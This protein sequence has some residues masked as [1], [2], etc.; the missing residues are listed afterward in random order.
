M[1]TV[2]APYR[3]Y[4][5]GVAGRRQPV[6]N[7]GPDPASFQWRFP[8][9]L[10][11]GDEEQNPVATGDGTLQRAI[12]GLPGAVEAVSVEVDNPVGLDAARAQTPVPTAIEGRVLVRN[13][14]LGNRNGGTRRRHARLRQRQG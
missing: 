6:V 4:A 7:G 9:A 5:V 3:G 8:L 2:R 13:S 14:Q 12:D 1:T 10:V 11:T